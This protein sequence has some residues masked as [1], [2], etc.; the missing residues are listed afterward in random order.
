LVGSKICRAWFYRLWEGSAI[1]RTTSVERARASSKLLAGG[2][3]GAC[4][5]AIR[6]IGRHVIVEGWNGTSTFSKVGRKQK[7]KK[8]KTTWSK[9]GLEKVCRPIH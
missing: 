9:D 1:V 4:F 6:H 5:Q 2:E 7:R 3:G 8:T